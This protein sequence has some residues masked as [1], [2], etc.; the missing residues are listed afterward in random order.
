MMLYPSYLISFIV[1]LL[2]CRYDP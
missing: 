2:C 1:V